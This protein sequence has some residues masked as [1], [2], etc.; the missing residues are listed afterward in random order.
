MRLYLGN[1]TYGATPS[2]LEAWLKDKGVE[3]SNLTW[4]RD[5]N[6]LRPF[7]FIDVVEDAGER[8]IS[9]LHNQIFKGRPI[10]V[11]NARPRPARY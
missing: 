11:N 6:G 4:P 9:E 3:I 8:I 5:N 10:N 1:I 7:C 2:E